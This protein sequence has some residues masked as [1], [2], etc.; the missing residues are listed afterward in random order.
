MQIQPLF[1]TVGQLL[2]GRLFKIPQYQRAYSWG[3]KQREDLFEDLEKVANGGD[4]ASHFMATIVGLRKK[5]VRIAADE[6]AELEVVD[7]Q[8][9]LTT[10]I[11]LL[12]A[13]SKALQPEKKDQAKLAEELDSLL[14]KQDD[15]SLVLLQTNHD[16]SHIF[17]NYIRSGAIPEKDV[18]VTTADRNLLDAIGECEEFVKRWTA[19]KK[20]SVIGLLGLVKNQLSVIF[21]EIEDE[22]LVYTVFEVLNSRGLDVT[23]FDKLKSLLMAL[24]F[25]HGDPG[26]RQATLSEL[27]NVWRDIYATIGLRQNLNR[28]TVRFAATLVAKEQPSRPLGEE[29]AVTELVSACGVSSKKVLETSRW[30]LKVTEA[31]DRLLSEWRLRAATQIVQARLVAIAVFLRQFSPDDEERILRRWEGVTFRIYGM[32]GNDAR[33]KVGD[34]VRLAWQIINESL[35]AQSIIKEL[36]IIGKEFA[37]ERALEG[38]AGEDCYNGWTEQLRYFLFRYEEALAEEMGQK[39]NTSQ[40]NKIWQD[41]PSKS[42]EHIRPRSWGGSYVNR[43]GNLTMLPPGINSKLQDS[44][45]RDKLKTYE[46]CGLLGS[47]EVAGV[48]KKG[49]W[50]RAAVEQREKAMLEWARQE[51]AD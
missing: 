20:E 50:S 25:E 5:K 46:T 44:D 38:L 28:E 12:K 7:G 35:S 3:R 30:L 19:G 8:Q 47:T 15:I 27:H 14:V 45:P 22:G 2:T 29:D 33:T 17:L 4:D 37:I 18:V 43:L 31:E 36:S 24:V 23:W 16:A 40:W 21:H 49:K 1:L 9:R 51:W 32:L 39:L 11:I 41:E 10:I 48:L 13:I 34:Y 6:Y 26:S 42:I